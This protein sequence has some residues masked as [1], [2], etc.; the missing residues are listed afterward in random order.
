MQRKKNNLGLEIR[1]KD[2]EVERLNKLLDQ[3]TLVSKSEKNPVSAFSAQQVYIVN[4]SMMK[5]LIA[6]LYQCIGLSTIIYVVF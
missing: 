1:Q 4:I 3:H 5:I 6:Y 2:Q